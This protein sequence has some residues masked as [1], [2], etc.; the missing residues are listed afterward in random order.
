MDSL[1]P[2]R[3]TIKNVVKHYS[4]AE[5]KVREATSNDPWGPSSTLMGEIALLTLEGTTGPPGAHAFN[6]ARLTPPPYA[7][8]MLDAD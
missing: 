7:L 4:T 5:C 3:R 2:M 8:S 1:N 6:Q